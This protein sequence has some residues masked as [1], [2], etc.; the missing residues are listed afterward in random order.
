MSKVTRLSRRYSQISQRGV[1]STIKKFVKEIEI[2]KKSMIAE[3]LKIECMRPVGT[4]ALLKERKGEK[5]TLD[6]YGLT[7]VVGYIPGTNYH[8]R[9]N[10]T[11]IT[12]EK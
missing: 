10:L 8:L 6:S 11:M 7:I 2:T 5:L 9:V 4:Y 3:S 12:K 1:E